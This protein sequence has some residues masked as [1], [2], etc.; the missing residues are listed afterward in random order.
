MQNYCNPQAMSVSICSFDT[1]SST[2]GG[3]FGKISPHKNFHSM[4]MMYSLVRLRSVY[5]HFDGFK[6]IQVNSAV[7]VA[8]LAKRC[9]ARTGRFEALVMCSKESV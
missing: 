7:V 8:N 1:N 9:F 3:R 6:R 5:M 4:L 2:T